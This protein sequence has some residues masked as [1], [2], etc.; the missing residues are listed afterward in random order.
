MPQTTISFPNDDIN[1]LA[2]SWDDNEALAFAV[3]QKI[4]QD[5]KSIDRIVTLAKGG[6][7]MT[8]S[9]VD[10]LEINK[11]ASIGVKFY[12]GINKR[13]KKPQIYQ[14]TP[15]SVNDEHVLL[16]D[17]VADTGE[18][19]VFTKK[20][21]QQKGVASVTTATLY[22]KP[23]SCLKPDYYGAETSAWIIFP[24]E[25]VDAMD[26]LGH[27]WLEQGCNLTDIKKRFTQLKFKPNQIDYY[28]ERLK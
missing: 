15:V 26:R 14:D 12:A 9:L 4:L 18:S 27:H 19:L 3:A 21:L 28:C 8:R 11:V 23:H 17:D 22:Y 24:Y 5:K 20:Y 13:L 7:P 16:F 25:T 6:W 2:P 1:Y 10:F